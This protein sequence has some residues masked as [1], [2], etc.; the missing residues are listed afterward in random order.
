MPIFVKII[1]MKE[2]V[3]KKMR[4][5]A[6]FKNKTPLNQEGTLMLHQDDM[7]TYNSWFLTSYHL[8]DKVVYRGLV[9]DAPADIENLKEA[10]QK[11]GNPESIIVTYSTQDTY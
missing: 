8:V 11:I 2:E 9:K 1:F 3:I 4:D 5:I 10:L 6:I 7:R